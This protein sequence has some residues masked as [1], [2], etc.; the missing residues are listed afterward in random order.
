MKT[1]PI[2]LLFFSILFIGACKQES[3]V[4]PE[5]TQE[6]KPW[7]RWWWPG[8]AVDRQN[9]QRE[10]QEMADAGIGGVEITSIYGV[11]GEEDRFIEYLSPQFSEMLKFT[12]E[13]A[14]SLGMGVDLPPG[15]GW[16]CGG[17]FVT[18]DKGLWSLKMH[19]FDVNAGTQFQIPAEI[20]TAA[21]LSFVNE[22]GDVAVLNP[23]EPFTAPA[24]G[25]V[26]VAERK[27][28]HDMVKR[29]S[30]GGKGWAIDTFNEDITEWYLNEFWNRLGID[31]GK[32]RCFFH[33]SFE[34]SGDFTTNFTDEFKR[35]RGYNL[36]EYLHVLAGDSEDSELAA[37]VK[38]DYR[39]TLSDLVLESFIQPMTS[40]ANSHQSLNRNQAHGSPGNILDLYAACDIP[41]T[42]IFGTVAPG[43]VNVLVNKFASSS[44]HVTGQK[45]VSSESFTWLNE[46]WTVTPADMMRASNRLFLAGVNHLFFHGTCYSPADAEWP[47]WLFYASTQ[48]NNRNPLWREMPAL[49]KYIERSQTI[50]QQS[51]P[52]NDL[53]VY[54]PYYDVTASDGR[55]FN[56][57]NIDKGDSSHWLRNTPFSNLAGDLLRSG[58]TF[59]YISDKQLANCELV[60]GEFVAEGKARYKAILLPETKYIPLETMKKL[61]RFIEKGGKV[62]FDKQ[63]PESVPGIFGLE[64][65]EEKLDAL[66]SEVDRQ[67][68]VGNV[69]ELLQNNG[70]RGEEMLAQKGFH[71]LKM[72]LGNEDWY[73]VLNCGTQTL[74]EWVELNSELKSC[75]F[76][77]PE[78]GEISKAETNGNSL[79]I[80][81]EPE[82]AVFI[83]CTD[84]NVNAPGFIYFEENAE[85]RDVEGSWKISFVEGGPVYPG[86][87]TTWNL[88]SW[89]SIGDEQ[90]TRF[91]GTAKYSVE[92]DWDD[93][94]KFGMLNLGEVKDCARL[95]LNG[96]NFGTLLGP[97]FVVKVDNLQQGKNSL[98]I[99]VTNVA[100]N[101]VRD[102]DIRGVNWRKFYDINFVSIEYT[103]FDASGW[104]V[105]EAGLLGDVSIVPIN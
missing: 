73:M 35:R 48:M 100:A 36:A 72:K 3:A 1:K 46:H 34:Y 95:K 2:I 102:L 85:K 69:F 54:W 67:K 19:V 8:N 23:D 20:E 62:F 101:R 33:D 47:G 88:A 11:K 32:L 39:E 43:S 58:F 75:F 18:E 74:D 59:D 9:I 86:N 79:R 52:Q 29:A 83:R 87:I 30:D 103:P 15:S 80:Q 50:L 66:K 55:L 68:H 77:F 51:L 16:R 5:P 65:R 60:N 57:L 7:T 6:S 63:L 38:S 37:R 42:E 70:V 90:T 76:Y 22:K 99:E 53:L 89:T 10:L 92:F 91:A 93:N 45:L 84:K 64:E 14:E 105:K 21:A 26:Y 97:S 94:V 61:V 25:K 49:F 12:I 56:S 81:L 40:W 17:P 98:E 27:K 82:R 24:K 96:K 31:N 28:N 4:W 41:E 44:A 78:T 104:E 71:Y 13:Q